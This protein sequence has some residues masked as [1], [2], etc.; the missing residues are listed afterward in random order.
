MSKNPNGRPQPSPQY[1]NPPRPPPLVPTRPWRPSASPHYPRITHPQ[2][3][4]VNGA[5]RSPTIANTQHHYRQNSPRQHYQHQQ[6]G[7]ST[8]LNTRPPPNSLQDFINSWRQQPTAIVGADNNLQ[9][10]LAQE[11]VTVRHCQQQQKL[12]LPQSQRSSSDP[13]HSLQLPFQSSTGMVNGSDGQHSLPPTLTAGQ[14]ADSSYRVNPASSSSLRV[15]SGARNQGFRI[16]SQ[17]LS[18]NTEHGE[19]C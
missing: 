9:R 10:Q 7:H 15:N 6:L 2:Q 4:L 18:N 3:L 1:Y 11:A 17:F 5:R 13:L 19:T 12:R 16:H 14:L 8:H